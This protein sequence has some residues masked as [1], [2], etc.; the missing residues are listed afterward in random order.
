VIVKVMKE[1]YRINATT[2]SNNDFLIG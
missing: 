1:D 2:Q